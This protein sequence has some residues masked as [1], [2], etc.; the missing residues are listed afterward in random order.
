MTSQLI[1]EARPASAALLN[2]LLDLQQSISA[3]DR[4]AQTYETNGAPAGAKYYRDLIPVSAPQAGE[5]YAFEVDLDACTGCKAC[6]AAC[7]SLN[8]LEESELWRSV[9][10]LVGGT[11]ELPVVQHVT[12]A[13]HHCIEPACLDGCPAE[14]YIKD[15]ATGIVRHL[16]DQCIGCQYCM[17]KCPYDVPVYSKSKGIV[18]KC[19]MCHQRLAVGE[20]PACVQ[21]CPNRAICIRLVDKQTILEQSEA[22]QFLPAAPEPSYTVPTTVYKSHRPLPRNALPVDYFSTRRSH[23]HVPLVFMLVLTQMSVGSFLVAHL[24]YSYLSLF[25]EQI[26]ESVRPLHLG[27]ALVLGLSGLG[28]SIF[29]LGR[30]RYAFRALLGLRTSW[31]SREILAFGVFAAAAATYVSSAYLQ[32]VGL[33]VSTTWRAGL[34]VAACATGYAAIMCSVMV[35]VD[36]RRPCW[37]LP[38]TSMKFLLTSLILGLPTALLILLVG[39]AVSELTVHIVMTEYGTAFCQVLMTAIVAKLLVEASVLTHLKS[40]QH[41][42]QKRSALLMTGEL[43]MATVRRFFFGVVGGVILPLV[44]AAEGT[45]AD[46]YHP[47][48]V[49]TATLLMLG[50]LTIGELHERYL[51]FAT[52]AAARM[53]GAPAS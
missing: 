50:L 41:T 31:L 44:L 24:T 9:G 16:D 39:S 33:S 18:R 32:L 3:V 7:H 26:A 6:V 52:S 38:L 2:E 23:S 20:A 8:G 19:D 45:L 27:A 11:S 42:P 47:L 35:Y 48:F 21:G 14:A 10:Q 28:A 25:R 15:P 43:S 13:C 34:G 46:S 5:Q 4:F 49:G 29:H 30:P 12:A 53:P 22:N 40:R 17:L 36:T 1:H 37:G 51:F